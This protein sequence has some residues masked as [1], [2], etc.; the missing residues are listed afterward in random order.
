MTRA[1]TAQG[2]GRTGP[3]TAQPPSSP[4]S[5][6]LAS[7]TQTFRLGSQR[8]PEPHAGAAGSQAPAQIPVSPPFAA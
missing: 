5:S 8:V 1:P 6:L 3:L 4:E 7:G 2:T